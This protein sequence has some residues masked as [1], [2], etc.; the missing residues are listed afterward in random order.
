[1]DLVGVR[2]FPVLIAP[3]FAAPATAAIDIGMN[4]PSRT[5]RLGRCFQQKGSPN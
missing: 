3:H 2:G 1:M 4:P 5:V